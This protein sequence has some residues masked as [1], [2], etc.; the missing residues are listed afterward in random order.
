MILARL[1]CWHSAT[2]ARR[3]VL[4]S[5]PPKGYRDR[6]DPAPW[7]ALLLPSGGW[8]LS[9]GTEGGGTRVDVTQLV[10]DARPLPNSGA[11][12]LAALL[13]GCKLP[14]WWVELFEVEEGRPFS[15]ARALARLTVDGVDR[16]RYRWTLRV[17]AQEADLDARAAGPGA[18]AGTGGLEGP[19]SL[20]G[21]GRE[22][23]IGRHRH[24]APT[25]LGRDPVNGCHLYSA[26][27]G[28]AMGG[29]TAVRS[30]GRRLVTEVTAPAVPTAGQWRQDKTRG[31]LWVG[32]EDLGDV[33][34][35]AAGVT[36]ADGHVIELPG[37]VAAYLATTA[38]GVLPAERVDGV[39]AAALDAAGHP[40]VIWLD[41]G[42]DT[43][44]RVVLDEIGTATRSDWYIGPTGLL[45][46]G[47]GGPPSG[48]S[49][50]TL[51][52][53]KD[54]VGAAPVTT[55]E[56]IPPRRVKVR[57]AHNAAA[58]SDS[59]MVEDIPDAERDDI[60]TEWLEVVDEDPDG[61]AAC[62]VDKTDTVE[63]VHATRPGALA[64][65]VALRADA[66]NPPALYELPM[67][68]IPRQGVGQL[69]TVREAGHPVFGGAG[70]LA[71]V[72]AVKVNLTDQTHSITVRV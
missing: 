46:F 45:T 53:G 10:L 35:A 48:V 66:Q 28:R 40:L 36:A 50:T 5:Q 42:D 61:G 37:E 14:G 64:L 15:E 7:W 43:G 19:A 33:T 69:V 21:K 56:D 20:E 30:R 58:L 13:A 39:A 22:L 59:D 23:L 51:R 38:S 12:R 2:A 25:Y 44:V 47:P 67:S 52:A 16:E 17:R 9:A 68:R 24:V 49:T 31:L 71:R 6:S 34:A 1:T 62:P 60:S 8:T 3:V 55:S 41:A 65:A 72:Q 26:T 29:Y 57:Y 32:G 54:F 18:Y 70:A 11:V 4:F 27:G 63:T